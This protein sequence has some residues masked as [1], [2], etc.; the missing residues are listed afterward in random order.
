MAWCQKLVLLVVFFTKCASFLLQFNNTPREN[1]EIYIY[2]SIFGFCSTAVQGPVPNN[3][4]DHHNRAFAPL[5]LSAT[6]RAKKPKEDLTVQVRIAALSVPAVSCVVSEHQ[7][8]PGMR[9]S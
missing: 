6:R 3:V 7:D 4:P 2:I 9:P 5:P 8:H 1:Y